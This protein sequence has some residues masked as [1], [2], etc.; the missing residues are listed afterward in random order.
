MSVKSAHHAPAEKSAMRTAIDSL[1]PKLSWPR[2][3][4]RLATS[5]MIPP[6]YPIAHAR[7]ETPSRSSGVAIS[8][9]KEL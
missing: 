4:T 7:E 1:I 9:R 3:S 8:G 6:A 2:K 5:R